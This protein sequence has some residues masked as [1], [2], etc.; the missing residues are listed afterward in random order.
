VRRVTKV[1]LR[2]GVRESLNGELTSE[3][4]D[5]YKRARSMRDVKVSPHR[6]A[7]SYRATTG[8]EH[9]HAWLAQIF[10]NLVVDIRAAS[11]ARFTLLSDH[12]SVFSGG[13]LLPVKIAGDSSQTRRAAGA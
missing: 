9:S 8:T 4:G 2:R 10:P 3:S 6:L 12:Q 11:S 1:R 13:A 7:H 5:C